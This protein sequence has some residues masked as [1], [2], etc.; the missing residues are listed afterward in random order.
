MSFPTILKPTLGR[1]V[2]YLI[3]LTLI[4]SS[5]SNRMELS[6]GG[7]HVYPT[8][9]ELKQTISNTPWAVVELEEYTGVPVIPWKSSE[10]SRGHYHALPGQMPRVLIEIL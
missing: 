2:P 5:A 8:N 9:G 10:R 7:T 4:S 3:Y 1:T 6:L